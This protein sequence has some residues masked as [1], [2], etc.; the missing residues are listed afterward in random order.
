MN[1]TDLTVSAVIERDGR[2]LIVEE[3]A[4]GVVVMNHPG[5]HIEAGESLEQARIDLAAA[6]RLAARFD[7]HEGIEPVRKGPLRDLG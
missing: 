7:L 3:R 4:S 6:L 2:F 1:S 5:G